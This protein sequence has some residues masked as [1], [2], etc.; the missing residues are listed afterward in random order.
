M[1]AAKPG[2]QGPAGIRGD[3]GLK[4]ADG[5]N[6]IQG[7]QGIQGPPG[8]IGD[9]NS[10]KNSIQPVTLW[11][12]DGELCKIPN[13]K[14][15]IDFGYGGSRIIDSGNLKFITDDNIDFNAGSGDGLT[16]ALTNDHLYMYGSR[17]LQFGH[18][19]DREANAGQISYG[20]HDGGV[21]GSL[22]IVGAGKNGQART[23]RIWDTLR[24]GDGI[25]RQDDDW[26][27]SIGDKNDHQSY[28]SGK[29]LAAKNL[30]AKHDV[31]T[32]KLIIGQ[33]QFQQHPNGNLHIHRGNIDDW[34]L[35]LTPGDGGN[36]HAKGNFH[37]TRWDK[38]M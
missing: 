6:G 5:I 14:K 29:G 13:G 26:I 12:A 7:I 23:V 34:S 32:S 10:V 20:R 11:C 8:N 31:Y 4:G 2:P 36:V 15:G 27:R 37:T 21:D 22:N 28:D 17:G 1:G 35:A 16:A 18:G 19:Y 30:W 9:A 3:T 25:L 33:W 24:I 38:W